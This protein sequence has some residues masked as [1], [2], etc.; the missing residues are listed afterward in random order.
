MPRLVQVD[1]NGDG[2]DI[3]KLVAECMAWF[4]IVPPPPS[5]AVPRIRIID[6]AV[7]LQ[8]RRQGSADGEHPPVYLYDSP[9]LH[10]VSKQEHLQKKGGG[11]I[12]HQLCR[13]FMWLAVAFGLHE[14][15]GIPKG[16]DTY[17]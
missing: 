7:P 14:L 3:R 12:R 4:L 9:R 13:R 1:A 16:R 8:L 11:G 5:T 17:E 15:L 2:C 6:G 10:K